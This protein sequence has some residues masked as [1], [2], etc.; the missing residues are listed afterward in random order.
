MP[1]AGPEGGG[2]VPQH[3]KASVTEPRGVV[4]E[5]YAPN[6]GPTL[7]LVVSAISEGRV[8]RCISESLSILNLYLYIWRADETASLPPALSVNNTSVVQPALYNKRMIQSLTSI[9]CG[10]VIYFTH[11]AMEPHLHN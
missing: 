10:R 1:G 3:Q 5:L 4:L 11:L 2:K 9:I 6:G 8:P 7:E